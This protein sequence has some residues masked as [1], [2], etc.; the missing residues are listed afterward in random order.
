MFVWAIRFVY[1]FCR[2]N[3]FFNV[4]ASRVNGP[5]RGALFNHDLCCRRFIPN[6]DDSKCWLSHHQLSNLAFH[7]KISS[8][9]VNQ[10]YTLK[11]ILS[12][13][14]TLIFD[15]NNILPLFKVHE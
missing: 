7:K 5:E 9:H 15:I 4:K 8:K 10:L 6:S 3:V 13:Y 2:G 12:S 11:L 14:T 1:R